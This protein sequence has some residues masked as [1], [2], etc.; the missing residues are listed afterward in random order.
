MHARVQV[1][2]MLLSH[3]IRAH[4]VDNDALA[5]DV[6]LTQRPEQPGVGNEGK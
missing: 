3:A 6:L 4:L 5:G 2:H 1:Q